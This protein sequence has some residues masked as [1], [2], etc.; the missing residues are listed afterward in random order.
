MSNDKP[1]GHD[2]LIALAKNLNVRVPDL[3]AMSTDRDP[4]KC[5]AE[6]QR[7][8]G[9]WFAEL[10]QRFDFQRGCHLRFIHYKLVSLKEPI[11]LPDGKIYQNTE[12]CFS[13]L[14]RA[15]TYARHL[16]L[17][18][19]DLLDDH[20]NPE[21]NI[22]A[23]YD[24]EKDEPG[25][26]FNN[27]DVSGWRLP[28][29]RCGEMALVDLSPPRLPT[30]ETS[31]YDYSLNDQV[32]HLEIWIEKSTMNDVLTPI[33]RR[34]KVNLVTGVGFQSI[35]G[36]VKLLQR[37]EQLPDDRPSRIFYVSDFDPAGDSMPVAVS[38]QIEFYIERFARGRDIKLT[39]VALTKEQVEHYELPCKPIKESDNAAPSFKDR[40]GVEGAVELDALEAIHPGEFA[41][42][43]IE[44]IRPYRDDDL[45][46]VM[47][48]AAEEAQASAEEQWEEATAEEREQLDELQTQVDAIEEKYQP[49]IDALNEKFRKE[50]E[51]IKQ[52]IEAELAPLGEKLEDVRQ[53]AQSKISQFDPDLPD[54][55]EADVDPGDEEDWLY[56]SSREYL[57]QLACYKRHQG[58][59]TLDDRERICA[60]LGC[61]ARFLPR[62]EKQRYCTMSCSRKDWNEKNR[63]KRAQAAGRDEDEEAES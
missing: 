25:W 6:F 19:A 10:W 13:K 46:N 17:V 37:L 27:E 62:R 50:A 52:E 26:W 61:E 9:G 60:R 7:T 8:H 31:G 44:A 39:P 55:P 53:A 20:R 33:C 43:M 1:T 40:R 56:D 45:E 58:N 4:F 54:R 30:V 63:K 34:W 51:T 28:T 12:R 42:I 49:R 32:F 29:L 24:D 16:G 35:S 57:E 47:E 23:D 59:E 3:I 38:R 15:S 18:G 41:K 21:P 11:L 36:T 22:F 14:N 2:D 5:G 48:E